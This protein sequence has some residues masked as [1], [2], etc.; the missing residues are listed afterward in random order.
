MKSRW[1]KVA[2]RAAVDED[3]LQI[4]LATLEE[5]KT[6]IQQAQPAPSSLMTFVGGKTRAV[7]LLRKMASEVNSTRRVKR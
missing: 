6:R 2:Q 1:E 3:V 5:A 7:N 4:V